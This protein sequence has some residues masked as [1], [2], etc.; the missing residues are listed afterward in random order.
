MQDAITRQVV[1]SAIRMNPRDPSIFFRLSG[2][3]LAHYMSGRFETAIDWAERAITACPS[4]ISP[5]SSGSQAW[6]LS[7]GQNRRARQSR[8]AARCCRI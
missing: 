2:L 1:A 3:A 4:G 8:P 5:I 6:L 7:A